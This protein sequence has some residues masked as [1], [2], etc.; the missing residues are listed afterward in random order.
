MLVLVLPV[1]FFICLLACLLPLL[2]FFIC[3][4][5]KPPNCAQKKNRSPL[6]LTLLPISLPILAVAATRTT[7]N[8]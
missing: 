6:S 7:T 3:F 1:A 4:L 2:S 5:A 8:C